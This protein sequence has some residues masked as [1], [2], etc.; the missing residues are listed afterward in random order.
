MN[1]L[2]FGTW[3]VTPTGDLFENDTGIYIHGERIQEQDWI[4]HAITQNW[5]LNS[6]IP[7][8]YEAVKINKITQVIYNVN[9][10]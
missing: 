10:L 3:E 7:A 6:F 1:P 8:F 9:Y 5:D 4:L 2:Q